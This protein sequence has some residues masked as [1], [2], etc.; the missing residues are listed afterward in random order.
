MEIRLTMCFSERAPLW[1]SIV[2]LLAVLYRIGAAEA[3]DTE[4]RW[5]ELLSGVQVGM[6]RDAV[7]KL[8]SRAHAA[9]VAADPKLEA[10]L[11][12]GLHTAL[13]TLDDGWC[14]AITFDWTGFTERNNPHV[15]LHLPEHKVVALPQLLRRDAALNEKIQAHSPK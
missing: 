13:Y 11:G 10:K 15:V 8:L 6:R 9:D 7:E 3:P 14:A 4:T 1:I 2:L 12:K 5:R